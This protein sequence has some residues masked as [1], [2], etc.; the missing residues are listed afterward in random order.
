VSQHFV[1]ASSLDAAFVT[2][3]GGGKSDGRS[4]REINTGDTS[5][6]GF[7]ESSIEQLLLLV[8]Y[9][10]AEHPGYGR[11]LPHEFCDLRLDHRAGESWPRLPLLQIGILVFAPEL[12][13]V[14][15]RQKLEGTRAIDE[16]GAQVRL[17]GEYA[18]PVQARRHLARLQSVGQGHAVP[19]YRIGDD[20]REIRRQVDE[21]PFGAKERIEKAVPRIHPLPGLC[22][23]ARAGIQKRIDQASLGGVAHGVEAETAN[24]L[25]PHRPAQVGHVAERLR[26][27]RENR[28]TGEIGA[29]E[30]PIAVLD[31][32]IEGSNN[33]LCA[34]PNEETDTAAPQGGETAGQPL[35]FGGDG[36]DG[37]RRAVW[38]G[39]L[40]LVDGFP[41]YV[42][43]GAFRFP[44]NPVSRRGQKETALIPKD[45][46]VLQGPGRPSPFPNR[47]MR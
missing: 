15:G 45:R 36:G 27:H 32:R 29:S 4:A 26:R 7:G 33:L 47:W 18:R 1:A 37:K 14:I 13:P 5:G 38:H 12:G 11:V 9:P 21:E 34:I 43:P 35:E 8:H 28:P 19:Q 25:R 3:S 46:A 23:I 39:T 10:K 30:L 41:P 16:A 24:D 22:Q 2:K 6:F 31:L 20:L 44:K 42:S 17:Q 40:V